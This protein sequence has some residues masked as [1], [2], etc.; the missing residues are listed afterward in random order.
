MLFVPCDEADEERLLTFNLPMC[1]R[2]ATKEWL[3]VAVGYTSNLQGKGNPRY[4]PALFLQHS[5]RE[6]TRVQR[7]VQT[8]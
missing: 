5:A 1:V 6:L 3:N 4:A 7:A 2:A 8:Q